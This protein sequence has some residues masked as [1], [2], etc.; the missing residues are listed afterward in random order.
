MTMKPV[1]VCSMC[2]G[3]IVG[4]GNDAQPINDGPCCDRCYAERVIP[5]RVRHA[6]ARCQARRQRR[7]AAMSFGTIA[8]IVG[9]AV[10]YGV[11]EWISR[12]RRQAA[13]RRRGDWQSDAL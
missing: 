5:E 1:Q 3:A 6:G 13:E 12:R 8:L 7:G 11:R 10:G 9:F 2:G 4:F